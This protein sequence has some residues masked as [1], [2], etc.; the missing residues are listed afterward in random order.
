MSHKT[1]TASLSS[2]RSCEYEI[3]QLFTVVELFAKRSD[4][5]TNYS[6]LTAEIVRWFRPEV[7]KNLEEQGV[8]IQISERFLAA[9][10]TVESLAARVRKAAME[11]DKSLSRFEAEWVL[12]ALPKRTQ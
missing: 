9:G 12:A 1:G 4:S 3:P 7:L 2:L 8:P 11:G 6:L 10:D 5:V